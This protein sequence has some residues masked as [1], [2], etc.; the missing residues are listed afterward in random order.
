[1]KEETADR[2]AEWVTDS[3][4]FDGR[5]WVVPWLRPIYVKPRRAL[6]RL[7]ERRPG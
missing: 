3:E 7:R 2:R 5:L 1:V 4:R 6:D